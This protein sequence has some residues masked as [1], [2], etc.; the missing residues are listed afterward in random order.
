MTGT[1]GG[2]G[3][4]LR[5]AV[6]AGETAPER[7]ASGAAAPEAPVDVR[8]GAPAP[9]R[10]AD[11][12]R[13]GTGSTTPEAAAATPVGTADAT[14]GRTVSAP[15]QAGGT[16]PAAEVTET[17]RPR[18]G[19]RTLP[20][21]SLRA[22]GRGIAGGGRATRDWSRRPAGRFVLPTLLL[23]GMVAAATAAGAYAVPAGAPHPAAAAS[24][25]PAQVGGPAPTLAPVDPS[26]AP[27]PS[28]AGAPVPTATPGPAG[29]LTR[30]ADALAGWAG[31]LAGPLSIPVP[32]LEAYGY[33]QLAVD[34]STPNCH[35]GWTTLAGI[36]KVES[37]H[38]SAGSATLLPDGRALPPIIGPALDGTNGTVLVRDTDQGRYDGDKVYD[39]AIGPMQFLPST[40]ARYG[41][42][43]DGD[44]TADPNDVDDAA[45][46]AGRY[47][48]AANRDLGHPGD[49]WTAVLTYN[50]VSD[51]AL[52][53]FDAANGYGETSRTV[54]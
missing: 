32:A 40:W 51:Y 42:D 29:G 3:R 54:T 50:A 2:T 8:P 34:R 47:L 16:S 19:F 23:L 45:M 11:A 31:R 28:S 13:A 48:C 5:P 4:T 53:V 1:D 46:T 17:G 41:T 43:A 6:P 26:A 25:G 18:R 36:G 12:T 21:R 30:P 7:P 14:P 35:L 33:A 38:G 20:S 39:R 37:N 10:P 9:E 24:T 49:W 22:A 44:G 15:E 27:V 52:R